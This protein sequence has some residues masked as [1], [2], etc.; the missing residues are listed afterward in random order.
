MVPA[1][2]S[3]PGE[4]LHEHPRERRGQT[5]TRFCGRRGRPRSFGIGGPAAPRRRKIVLVPLLGEEKPP[6]S[7]HVI[8]KQIVQQKAEENQQLQSELQSREQM[9]EA[10][11][12][13]LA[14]GAP[15]PPLPPVLPP[16]PRHRHRRRARAGRKGLRGE[17]RGAVHLI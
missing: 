9:L 3:K 13:R 5:V 15:M 14:R 17:A 2:P 12:G 4:W 10:E 8:N 6:Y 1:D 16:P 11:N 7:Q